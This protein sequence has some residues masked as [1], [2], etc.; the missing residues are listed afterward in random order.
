MQSSPAH[1]PRAGRGSGP[2]PAAPFAATPAGS[3]PQPG[4]PVVLSLLPSLFRSLQV[5]NLFLLHL[6]CPTYIRVLCGFM[7]DSRS[8]RLGRGFRR[9]LVRVALEHARRRELTELVA[10]HV[11]RHIDRD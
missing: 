4:I 9:R 2:A 7:W 3:A 11:L 5:A 8:L 6:A 1:A 10:H